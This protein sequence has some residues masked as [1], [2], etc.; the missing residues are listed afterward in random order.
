ML[1]AAQEK[2]LSSNVVLAQTFTNNQQYFRKVVEAF[3]ME[4]HLFMQK[5]WLMRGV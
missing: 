3:W 1:E 2:V 5:L 4:R